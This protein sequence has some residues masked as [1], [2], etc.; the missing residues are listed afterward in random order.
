MPQLSHVLTHLGTR[1]QNL[2]YLLAHPSYAQVR[3]TQADRTLYRLLHKPWFWQHQVQTVLDVG[4][5]QGQFIR[6][7]LTLMPEVRILGFEPNP[8]VVAYLQSQTWPADQVQIFPV[9]CGS[10]ATVAK[11]KVTQFSPSS[12]FLNATAQNLREFPGTSL[13][14]EVEVSV[15][16]LDRIL[17]TVP[18]LTPPF[19]LKL[20]VQGQELQVL[21]GATDIL[22]QVEVILCE[23][24]VAPLYDGQANLADI[25]GFLQQHGFRLVDLGDPIRS[26]H[27]QSVLFF[28]A[29]FCQETNP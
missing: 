16:R 15:E 24:N 7:I 8:D 21:Q 4:S 5:N 19:L 3:T 22:P 14:H 18:T 9:A 23:I 11:L 12:S 27:D 6:T 2:G 1:I 28:D 26:S 25:S 29:V 17:A 13:L 10:E 20:D